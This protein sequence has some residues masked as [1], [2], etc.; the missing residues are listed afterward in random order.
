MNFLLTISLLIAHFILIMW[1]LM[2]WQHCLLKP[3][4]QE[5]TFSIRLVTN[6]Y[7]EG[8]L[9]VALQ[10]SNAADQSIFLTTHNNLQGE[11]FELKIAVSYYSRHSAVPPDGKN[12]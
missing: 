1:M 7:M 12:T 4:Y 8:M 9:P 3:W 2:L 10:H 11:D 5:N 6:P